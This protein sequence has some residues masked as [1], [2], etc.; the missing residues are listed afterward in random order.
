MPPKR[1]APQPDDFYRIRI[2]TDA[3]LSPDGRKVAFNLQTSAPS[4]TGY[5]SAIWLAAADGSGEPR[6]LT[7]GAKND[8]Q[9]RFSPDGRTL[10]FLSDRRP[11]VEDE[12]DASKDREDASQVHLLP[13]DGPGEARRLTNLP[14]GVN[15]L[16]WSPDGR[17]IAVLSN[18]RGATREADAKA[19]GKRDAKPGEPLS[20]YRF[21]DRLGYL[22]NG[23]GWLQAHE[24]QVWIVEVASGE[25]RQLTNITPGVDEI[26]WSPDGKRIAIT[27]Q[28]ER[29]YDLEFRVRIDVV[30]VKS[31]RL[32]RI[33]GDRRS[34]F[35]RPTWL[36]DGK[37][38]AALGGPH[39]GIYYETAIWLF[40]ADGSD[41][42]PGAGRDLTSAHDLM[43][44][45]AMGS[46][47]AKADAARLVATPDGRALLFLAPHAGAYDL[48]RIELADG[49][50]TRLT[51]GSH[52]LS[53]FDAVPARG[54]GMRVAAIRSTPTQMPDVHVGDLRSGAS[55]LRLRRI[56]E[57][58]RE[59]L[60]ELELREPVERHVEVDGRDIQG[61][62]LRAGKGRRPTVV[63]IHGGPHTL[64]GWA[65]FLEFQILA[66][67]GMSVY[68]CNPRG[69]E[70]YGRAFNE[71]NIKDWG[72]GPMR[73]VLAGVDALVADG[74]ADPDRLGVTGGSY[75]GYLTN[76][77][78]AHDHRFRAAMT[79]RNVADMATLFLTGDLAGTE[80]PTAEFGAYP[81]QDPAYFTSISPLTYASN[82][83]TPLLIQ[84]SERDLR[85]TV[86]HAE[87]MFAV[88]RKH[89][90]PVR[91]MRVP[92]ETHELTRSGSPFRRVENLVQARA[93]F[94]HFL[95]DGKRRLP[96]L[97]KVRAGI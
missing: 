22:A 90:R 24:C 9:A 84:H 17:R 45:S 37:T 13:L 29:D 18:S 34:V 71:A 1:R 76:W 35:F 74:L 79:C 26:A 20:D 21:T 27:A 65:P 15:E 78:V 80:W 94:K 25:A 81:W 52:Y 67:T 53:G 51:D 19:R 2:A 44:G 38:I 32:T 85:T 42:K 12:P 16:A 23:P 40:A 69:S 73:D 58:N 47:L 4:R 61:W 56:T 5:R 82:I 8:G 59:L 48:W 83:R 86:A 95:V 88:L 97:P 6:Q 46:D 68:Y 28:H 89:R 96:P 36:P 41:A 14:R 60:G 72:P 63:Q 30:D 43:P 49:G 33:A 54:G 77:I 50:V 64:Y 31:G 3:R 93:W 11:L 70:G 91:L 55:R 66:G 62:L 87:A 57:V 75:G 39:P 7:I 10:A 92:D